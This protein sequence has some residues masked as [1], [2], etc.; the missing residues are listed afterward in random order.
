MK[1]HPLLGFVL[2]T[3]GVSWGLGVLYFLFP[4]ELIASFGPPSV[5]NP[6]FILAVSAPSFAGIILTGITQGVT[7][8]RELLTRLFRWRVALRWYLIVLLGMPAI[9]ICASAVHAVWR[10][11]ALP[12]LLERRSTLP[13]SIILGLVWGLWHLPGFFLAGLPQNSLLCFPV[14]RDGF[15]GV[16]DCGGRLPLHRRGAGRSFFADPDSVLPFWVN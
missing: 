10:G 3:F 2:L 9:S 14:P 7:G 11:Y 6:V 12:R 4:W 16:G 13:A 15:P 1:R 5:S 8:L